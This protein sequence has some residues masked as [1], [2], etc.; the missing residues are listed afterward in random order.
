M[1]AK[2]S[3]FVHGVSWSLPVFQWSS[4]LASTRLVSISP[5]VGIFDE[6]SPIPGSDSWP[7]RQTSTL[8]VPCR[9]TPSG[10]GSARGNCFLVCDAGPARGRGVGPE[11]TKLRCGGGG[12]GGDA[13]EFVPHHVLL[14]AAPL[15]GRY[16]ASGRGRLMRMPPL[17]PLWFRPPSQPQLQPV[18]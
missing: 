9:P 13:T 1:C 11:A 17:D 5:T 6:R 2:P 16:H 3:V 12:P 15:R 8:A 18:C 7:H 10:S 14:R 4:G